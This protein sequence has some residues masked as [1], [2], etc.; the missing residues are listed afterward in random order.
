M[1]SRLTGSL[2]G[3]LQLLMRLYRANWFSSAP[4]WATL[5]RPLHAL[6]RYNRGLAILAAPIDFAI[7][8]VLDVADVTLLLQAGLFRMFTTEGERRGHVTVETS[9]SRLADPLHTGAF[10]VVGLLTGENAIDVKVFKV[11]RQA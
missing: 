9:P 6:K 4:R 8:A 5:S 10:Q 7:D 2:L 1:L 11:V 3:L